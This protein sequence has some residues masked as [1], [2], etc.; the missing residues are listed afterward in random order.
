[1][2][3]NQSVAA[4]FGTQKLERVSTANV[5]RELQPAWPASP[6]T[7][8]LY[9]PSI[10]QQISAYKTTEDWW[11]MRRAQSVLKRSSRATER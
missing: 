6:T 3:F 2:K 4:V 10:L 8:K 1:M 9:N 5:D 11:F 7:A